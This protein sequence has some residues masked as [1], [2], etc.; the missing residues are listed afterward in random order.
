V[1]TVIGVVEDFHK[2]SLNDEITPLAMVVG[3]SPSIVSVKVQSADMRGVIESVTS[4]WKKF[5]PYQSIRYSF[6]D[7]RYEAMYTDVQRLGSIFTT[8][9]ILAIVVACL[10]LFA[11]SSFMVEQRGKEI[12]IRLVLGASLR[13]IFSLLTMNFVKLVLIAFVIA[14][15][16]AWYMMNSWLQ[17]FNYKTDIGWDVFVIPGLV[18][19]VIALMTVSYQS[20]RAALLSPVDSLR[21]E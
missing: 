1:Y 3:I 21:T 13:S 18:A 15:P 5:N 14:S 2:E 7:E 10:G 12:S 17:D 6:L 9:S 4:V 20:I 19:V 16:V 11:L 8:F